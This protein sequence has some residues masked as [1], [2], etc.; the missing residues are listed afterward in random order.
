M[1]LTI[2]DANNPCAVR[3]LGNASW[4]GQTGEVSAGASGVF[5]EFDTMASGIRAG[6]RNL[7]TYRHRHG[8]TSPRAMIDRWAPPVEN[9]TSAYAAFV[10]ERMGIAPDDPVPETYPALRSLIEAIIAYE[11]GAN[12]HRVPAKAVN[13]AFRRMASEEA[14]AGR[15]PA[16]YTKSG[17][18]RAR[19]GV[20]APVPRLRGWLEGVFGPIIGTALYALL[21]TDARDAIPPEIWEMLPALHSLDRQTALLIGGAVIIAL[22]LWWWRNSKNQE[23]FHGYRNEGPGGPCDFCGRAGGYRDPVSAPLERGAP[24]ERPRRDHAG[25]NADWPRSAFGD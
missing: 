8:L 2:L 11:C 3:P 17:M 13:A 24:V 4:N 1:T 12:A 7:H 20:E 25:A 14:R 9:N 18:D 16:P 6:L 5:A 19:R 23:T 10:A 21:F 15:D 22:L